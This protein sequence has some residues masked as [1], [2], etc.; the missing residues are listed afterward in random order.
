MVD[1]RAKSRSEAFKRKVLHEIDVGLLTESSACRKYHVGH[2]SVKRWRRKLTQVELMPEET[3]K[4]RASPKAPSGLTREQKEAAVQELNLYVTSGH[5]EGAN[6][7]TIAGRLGVSATAI[8]WWRKQMQQGWA[9]GDPYKVGRRQALA[10]ITN[11]VGAG[12]RIP[13]VIKPKTVVA[14]ASPRIFSAMGLLKQSEDQ[15]LK[16]I[17]AGRIKRLSD[18][19]DRVL[20]LNALTQLLYGE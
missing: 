10:R 8:Y 1:T 2:N 15:I 18:H 3:R 7:L 13:A 6:A 12:E 9:S 16:D 5:K 14:V 19:P 11:G 17:R 4:P 20:A